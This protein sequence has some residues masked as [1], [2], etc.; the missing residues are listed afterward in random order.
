MPKCKYCGSEISK[1]KTCGACSVK[2]R[3]VRE[4]IEMLAPYKAILEKRK[5]NEMQSGKQNI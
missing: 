5:E 2:L 4:L 1:G 3:L